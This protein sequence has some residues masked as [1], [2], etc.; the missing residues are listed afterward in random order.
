M[1]SGPGRHSG[2]RQAE[3][4]VAVHPPRQGEQWFQI[5]HGDRDHRQLERPQPLPFQKG[6]IDSGASFRASAN[7]API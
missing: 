5:G 2:R 4:T 3:A 7:G 1:Q 6:R